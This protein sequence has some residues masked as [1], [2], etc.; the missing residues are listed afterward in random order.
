MPW[1]GPNNKRIFMAY[2]DAIRPVRNSMRKFSYV[3]V[4]RRLSEY[5][6]RTSTQK[7]DTLQAP[8]VAERLVLWAIR[9]NP[10]VYSRQEMKPSDLQKSLNLAWHGMDSEFRWFSPD[11]PLTLSVRSLLLAQIP[12]QM[13][14]TTA[15][16]VRQIDLVNRLPSNSRLYATFEH[17]LG[18]PPLDYLRIAALFR[19]NSAKNIGRVFTA[20]YRRELAGYFGEGSAQ[21]FLDMLVVPREKTAADMR[22]IDADE[23]FQPNLMYRSPFTRYD[24]QWFYWGRCCLD[25]H[26]EYALSDIVG[27]SGDPMVRQKFESMFEAYVGRS[28]QRTG[29]IVL[30]EDEVRLRFN[31]V[32]GCCDFAVLEDDTVVLVEV[33]NKALTHTLPASAALRTYRS[34]LKATIMK[35]AEQL[36]NT[37]RA[38][39]AAQPDAKIHRVAATYGDLLL[40]KPDYLF[41]PADFADS[42][43]IFCVDHLD[44]LTEAVRLRQCS[45]ESFFQNYIERQTTPGKAMF[46]VSELLGEPPYQLPQAPQ[47]VMDTFEPFLQAMISRGAPKPS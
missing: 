40:G 38:V 11:A 21:R 43:H 35:A 39:R 5:I 6:H 42:V 16:F 27:A 1:S 8:W 2:A 31:V 17:E 30:N 19:L 46:S 10:T 37:A 45:L 41:E 14:Q 20:N 9:D 4:L 23:W 24:S 13:G 33:K 15:P 25:R 18:M 28:L 22:E 36:N 7:S 34:R 32:G 44:H 47:Y 29:C 26:L 12:H 3:S